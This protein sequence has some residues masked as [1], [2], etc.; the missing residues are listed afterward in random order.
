M[1]F[2]IAMFYHSSTLVINY[3]RVGRKLIVSQN[4]DQ[5]IE[6]IFQGWLGR[7]VSRAGLFRPKLDESSAEFGPKMRSFRINKHI[8][9]LK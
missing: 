7:V 9:S 4:L 3:I 5:L 2:S 8:F 6:P 1:E